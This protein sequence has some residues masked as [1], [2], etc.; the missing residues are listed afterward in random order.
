ML[1]NSLGYTELMMKVG[2]DVRELAKRTQPTHIMCPATYVAPRALYC[3]TD[4][5]QADL[6]E[7]A[8]NMAQALAQAVPQAFDEPRVWDPLRL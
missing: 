6:T 4:Q 7:C 5:Q 1:L 2:D 3:L 8:T